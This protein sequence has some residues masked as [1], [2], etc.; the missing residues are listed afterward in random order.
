MLQAAQFVSTGKPAIETQNRSLSFFFSSLLWCKQ[1]CRAAPELFIKN[2]ER[3]RTS[4]S[5][6]CSQFRI[7]K[8]ILK[9]RFMLLFFSF[10]FISTS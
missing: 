2:E 6:F 3:M 7:K 8:F 4:Q 9:K 10:S 5:G 1:Y